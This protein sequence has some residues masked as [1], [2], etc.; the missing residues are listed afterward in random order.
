MT[1]A[2]LVFEIVVALWNCSCCVVCCVVR[3]LVEGGPPPGTLVLAV[4]VAGSGCCGVSGVAP[5]GE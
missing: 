4:Q 2:V 3:G 1:L 5:P